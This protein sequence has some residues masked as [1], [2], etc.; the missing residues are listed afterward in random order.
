MSNP[1]APNDLTSLLMRFRLG[2]HA[3]STDIEKAFLHVGLDEDDRDVTWFFWLTDPNDPDSPLQVYRFKAVLFGAT[4]SPFI[5]NATI[6]KHLQTTGSEVADILERDLYVDNIISFLDRKENAISFYKEARNTMRE[7][8]FN[9]RSWTSNNIDLRETAEYD[10]V[11]NSDSKTKVL[12][13]RWEVQSDNLSFQPKDLQS[14]TDVT[15]REVLQASSR[16]Y[17]PLWSSKS[18]NNPGQDLHATF[19]AEEV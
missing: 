19:M 2:T 1:P 12:G 6:M 10:H 7:A 5:L 9:L 4:C 8:G 15:K 17:D 3:T 16:I 14:P 13:M 18:S 11:L